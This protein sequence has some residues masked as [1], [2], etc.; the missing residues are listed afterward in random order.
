[1][2]SPQPPDRGE[3]LDMDYAMEAHPPTHNGHSAHKH[4]VGKVD[5]VLSALLG[6]TS[7]I[8]M[9]RLHGPGRAAAAT[10]GMMLLTRAATGHSKVY[11]A[12]GVS[13]ASLAEGGGIDIDASVTIMRPREELYEFWRDVTNLPLFMRH[14]A[15][16]ED[17][18]NGVT[19][20]KAHGPRGIPAEW[21]A[22]LINEERNEFLAW[23][24][25]PGSQIENAGSVHFKDAGD[26]GTEVLLNMRYRPHA[27]IPG[28]V[29][30]KV[31]NPLTE[32]DI[33]ADLRRLKHVMETGVDITTEGQPSGPDER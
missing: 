3:V 16:V 24:S 6:A 32:A 29:L 12:L 27:P 15:S 2:I 21:D 14:L 19:H 18:G 20:W 7:L 5:R 33:V 10:S 30:A 11:Q 25:M 1:M 23:Q 26:K 4:N 22:E 17:V 8:G 28:F 31:L 13:S 9:P